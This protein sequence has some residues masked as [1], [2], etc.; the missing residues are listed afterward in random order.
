MDI[1]YE[2][3]PSSLQNIFEIVGAEKF[4]EI[5]GVYSGTMVYFP[6]NKTLKKGMRNRDII[7]RYNGF[8]AFELAREYEISRSYVLWIIS[9]Y[10]KEKRDEDMY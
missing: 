7:R 10:K 9:N 6:T 5:I 1:R 2:D 4:L 8:N 3:I